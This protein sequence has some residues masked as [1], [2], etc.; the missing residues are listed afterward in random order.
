MRARKVAGRRRRKAIPLIFISY[1]HK[2]RQWLEFVLTHFGPAI[3][4]RILAV[5]YDEKING[6]EQFTKRIKLHLESCCICILLV[7][8]NSLQSTYIMDTEM[9]LMRR[10]LKDE[11]ARIFPIAVCQTTP[12]YVPWLKELNIRPLDGRPLEALQPWE[13]NKIMAD[14]V[15][16]IVKIAYQPTSK[17]AP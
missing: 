8:A 15:S 9:K 1:S 13:Q 11:T 10:R 7:S 2:D 6:G 12:Q 3:K 14:L 5:W 16:E 4:H 17:V